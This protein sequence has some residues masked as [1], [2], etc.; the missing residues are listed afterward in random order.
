MYNSTTL[1]IWKACQ[2]MNNASAIE[3]QGSMFLGSPNFQPWIVLKMFLDFEKGP[4]YLKT[5]KVSF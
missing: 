1:T 2:I 4:D 5:G 3:F